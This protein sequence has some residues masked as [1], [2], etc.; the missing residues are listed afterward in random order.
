MCRNLEIFHRWT[1]AESDSRLLFQKWSKG[2]VAFITKKTNKT[3]FGTLEWN[4]LGDFPHFSRV[5]VH[6]GPSLMFQISST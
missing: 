6:R 2:R 1:H 5:S 4:P 3:C